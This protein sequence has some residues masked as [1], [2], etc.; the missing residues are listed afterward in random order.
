MYEYYESHDEYE[1]NDEL[2]HYGILGMKWGRRKARAESSEPR[3]TFRERRAAKTKAKKDAIAPD[4]STMT[5]KQLRMAIKRMNLEQQY[6]R[7]SGRDVN[8]GRERFETAL[9]VIGTTAAVGGNILNIYYNSNKLANLG[10]QAIN[11]IR[12]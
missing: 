11:K 2:Y 3:Q 12:R 7:L 8:R 4:P 9:K 10:S 5:N 1:S 6:S